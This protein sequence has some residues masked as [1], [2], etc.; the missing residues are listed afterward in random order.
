MKKKIERKKA[1]TYFRK[2]IRG[3]YLKQFDVLNSDANC[4]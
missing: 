3:F 4:F 1:V 2:F